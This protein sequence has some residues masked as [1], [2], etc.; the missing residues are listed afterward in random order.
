MLERVVKATGGPD[1]ARRGYRSPKR[2]QAALETRRRIRSTAERLFLRDGY[3]PT[4]TRAISREAGVAEMT[5][6]N[7]FPS[8]AALLS[9]IVRVNLRGDDRDAPVP[10]RTIWPEILNSPADEILRRF[11]EFNGNVLARTARV[12]ALA[13]AAA[14][15]DP[16][17][18]LR[19]DNAHGQVRSDFRQ[20]ADALD[21]N[22]ALPDTV[23]PQ[24]AADTIYVLA[25]EVVYLRLID[26][27]G[28]STARYV[29]WLADILQTSLTRPKH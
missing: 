8:K 21:A 16:E 6:F 1:P 23:T 20:V 7:A 12:L 29:N 13:E 26:E 15:S 17:L 9:E 5:L 14:D 11:A 3:I 27:C 10:N 18:A 28:W 19:R 4:T 2:E 22:G 24:H 25:N